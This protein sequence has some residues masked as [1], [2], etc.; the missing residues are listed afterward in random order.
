MGFSEL[1]VVFLVALIVIGPKRLPEVAR[2]LGRLVFKAQSLMQTV[3]TQIDEQ[4]KN[5]VLN[6]SEKKAE[7]VDKLYLEEK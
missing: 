4:I 2:M 1:L 6:E 5:E 3:Q 7:K